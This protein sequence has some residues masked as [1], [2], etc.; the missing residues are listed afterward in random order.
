MPDSKKKRW[1]E[2]LTFW[3]ALLTF[4][5]TIVDKVL[6]Y[7]APT[8]DSADPVHVVI[9]PTAEGPVTYEFPGVSMGVES[10]A[11][12]AFPWGTV[13]MVAALIILVLIFVIKLR[14]KRREKEIVV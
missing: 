13:L 4:L 10:E 12:A 9:E 5:T 11:P 6:S 14:R 3:T 2:N 8:K 1:G 7:I